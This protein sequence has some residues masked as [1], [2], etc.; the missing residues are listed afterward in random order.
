MKKIAAVLGLVFAL[1]FS[2]S[3]VSSQILIN[4]FTVDPQSDWNN[5]SGVSGVDEFVEFYNFGSEEINLSG[6]KVNLI[7]GTPAAQ[8]LTG[9]IESGEYFVIV[10]PAGD[11]AVGGGRIELHNE[12]ELIDSVSY[13]S[14]DDGNESD[15]APDGNS[16]GIED[17]CVSRIPD[18]TDSDADSEDFE[19]TLCTFLLENSVDVGE[20]V[21][22]TDL[23]HTPACVLESNVTVFAEIEGSIEEVILSLNIDGEWENLTLAGNSPGIYSHQIDFAEIVGGE[24]SWQ[25]IVEGTNGQ[26]SFGQIE[27]AEINSR[28]VLEINPSTPDGENGWYTS[29]PSFSLENEDADTIFYQW[30][31]EDILNYTSPFGLEDSVNNGHITGGIQELKYWSDVCDES[32]NEFLGKFDFMNPVIEDLTPADGSNVLSGGTIVISAHIDEVYAQNS[33]V[34]V[35]ETYMELDGVL[36]DAQIVLQN[37]DAEISYEVNASELGNIMHTVHVYTE[38]KSGRVS[39]ESWQFMV[40]TNSDGNLTLVVNYPQSGVYGTRRVPFNLTTSEEVEELSY[41]NYNDPNP[42]FKKLCKDCDEFGESKRKLVSVREG[43]NSLLFRAV[44]SD[45]NVAEESVEFLVDSRAPQISSTSPT[46]GFSSG[47]LEIVFREENPVSLV[48]DYGTANSTLNSS[49]DFENDCE[50][51]SNNRMKCEIQLNVEEFNGEEILYQVFLTDIADEMDE[52]RLRRI[53]IDTVAP[54]VDYFNYTIEGRRVLLT[55]NITEMNFDKV[56]YIDSG[57]SNPR[58]KSVCSSLDDGVCEK[59]IFFSQGSHAID[60]IAYDEAGNAAIVANDLVFE[61]F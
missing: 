40:G 55:M 12:S 10:N 14:W 44:D 52:T 1:V 25:F 15:N 47:L 60:V 34:N 11:L 39:E 59:R 3:L 51:I 57:D 5:N 9:T 41:I 21:T 53:E 2:V 32:A 33:G 8:N 18:A 31:S 7:D 16:A 42:K 35:N 50:E 23:P 28:T 49:V 61:I 24:I 38:D 4:E 22:I 19:K 30:D 58:E 26:L 45:G 46:R 48:V 27:S 54:V 29:E 36:V 43:V 37:L 17:E 13:G 20:N 6:W 56:A